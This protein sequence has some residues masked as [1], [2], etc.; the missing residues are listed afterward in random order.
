[1]PSKTSPF[2]VF[3]APCF[4]L[5]QRQ[6]V[7]V[8]STQHF[9]AGLRSQKSRQI[10]RLDLESIVSKREWQIGKQPAVIGVLVKVQVRPT[11]LVG[12]DKNH[13]LSPVNQLRANP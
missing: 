6:I 13:L 2:G 8:K 7:V 11:L 5:G 9:H 10:G 3:H 1:M 4:E 12:K